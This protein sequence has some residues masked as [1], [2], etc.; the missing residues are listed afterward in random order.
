MSSDMVFLPA[1]LETLVYSNLSS[2]MMALKSFTVNMNLIPILYGES[3]PYENTTFENLLDEKGFAV[4]GVCDYA[5][6]E[7]GCRVPIGLKRVTVS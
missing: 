7:E 6:E 5:I 2:A 3:F 4:Y 1:H